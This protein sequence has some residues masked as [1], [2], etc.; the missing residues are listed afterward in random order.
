MESFSYF[1]PSLCRAFSN[2]FDVRAPAISMPLTVCY[3]AARVVNVTQQSMKFSSDFIQG[4]IIS[5]N[6]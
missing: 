6:S 5:T 4:S 1:R 3:S 2:N